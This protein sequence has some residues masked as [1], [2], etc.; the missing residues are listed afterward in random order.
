MTLGEKIKQLRIEQGLKQSELAEKAGISRVAVG[1]YERNDRIPNTDITIKIANALRVPIWK[2]F[3]ENIYATDMINEIS[4]F[5]HFAIP[6]KPDDMEAKKSI[7]NDIINGNI[8]DNLKILLDYELIKNNLDHLKN[9]NTPLF[10][11][12]FEKALNKTKLNM[13]SQLLD[14]LNDKGKEEAI[15]RV[16][17]LTQLEQYKKKNDD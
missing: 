1:N 5:L 11:Q 3:G 12:D 8:S 16:H 14:K 15:V 17:E 4:N 13:I 7:I 9:P 10:K 2:I 6:M